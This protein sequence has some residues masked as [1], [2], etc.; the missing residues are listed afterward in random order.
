MKVLHNGVNS[1]LFK[2]VSSDKKLELRRNNDLN[3]E[4][5]FLW[6]SQDRPKK[7]LELALAAFGE[8]HAKK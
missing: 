6:C 1:R 7:G 8:V 5:V 2:T 3:E 4:L